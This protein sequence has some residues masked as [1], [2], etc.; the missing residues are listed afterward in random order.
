MD[1]E[2]L[3]TGP[4]SAA[5]RGSEVLGPMHP[6]PSGK[7]VRLRQRAWRDPYDGEPPGWSVR[8]GSSCDDGNR[9]CGNDDGCWA[10]KCASRGCSPLCL[11]DHPGGRGVLFLR[12]GRPAGRRKGRHR[13]QAVTAELYPSDPMK[14]KPAELWV[15][16][17]PQCANH[18]GVATRLA[19]HSSSWPS[20]TS[21]ATARRWLAS[22]FHTVCTTPHDLWKTLWISLS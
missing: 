20:R 14:G 10:G 6:R 16:R 4:D 2:G 11:G 9:G 7:H 22:T 19:S 3:T 1:D 13:H 5:G 17:C 15:I 18:T 12:P 21:C 8:R